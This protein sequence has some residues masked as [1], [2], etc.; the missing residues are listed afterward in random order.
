MEVGFDELGLLVRD[1]SRVWPGNGEED[2]VVGD[3]ADRCAESV[4]E[5]SSAAVASREAS[6]SPL[7]ESLSSCTPTVH[8]ERYVGR[9]NA[10]A[11]VK[12]ETVVRNDN[13]TGGHTVRDRS[14]YRSRGACRVG[15]S[16]SIFSK[17]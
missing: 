1:A 9:E 12:L 17:A 8:P 11:A 7:W 10:I 3:D 4:S 2:L 14:E 6:S 16:T 15:A 13:E 5:C